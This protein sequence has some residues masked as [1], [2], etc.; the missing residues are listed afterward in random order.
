M[1]EWADKG[2]PITDPGIQSFAS[3]Q[4]ADALDNSGRSSSAPDQGRWRDSQVQSSSPVRR[5]ATTPAGSFPCQQSLGL[6]GA[7]DDHRDTR[8]CRSPLSR[9]GMSGRFHCVE[10][11]TDNSV[12]DVKNV[13]FVS[14]EREF[15][16]A[17]SLG[18]R[19]E[20]AP[21]HR[22]QRMRWASLLS[23]GLLS[24]Q[25]PRPTF[26]KSTRPVSLSRVQ[27]RPFSGVCQ[28][29]FQGPPTKS[30]RVEISS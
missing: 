11:V 1:L 8:A 21:V 9:R 26:S 13:R 2:Q 20:G 22:P 17:P 6:G 24:P 19:R 4:A 14:V 30:G 25:Q 15:R 10:V 27:T 3:Q 18:R 7:C 5:R 16:Q 23:P 12:A 29:A 28:S